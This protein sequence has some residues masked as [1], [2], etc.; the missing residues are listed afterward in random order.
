MNATGKTKVTVPVMADMAARGEKPE[1]LLW[2]GSAGAYD[3]RYKH[4][5]RAFVKILA[6]LNVDYAVL[7]TEESSSGDVARRA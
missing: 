4:V 5:T 2:V 7:G 1:Y 3:D 6:F